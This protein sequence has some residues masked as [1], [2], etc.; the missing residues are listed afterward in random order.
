MV[1]GGWGSQISRLL[2][3]EGGK[4]VSLMHRPSLPPP[5]MVLIYDGGWVNPRIT[6][7][8]G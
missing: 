5:G 7:W 3:H 2:A 6:V 1:P 4:V 8:P